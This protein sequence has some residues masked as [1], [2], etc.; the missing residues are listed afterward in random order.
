MPG[1]K[2]S[3]QVAFQLRNNFDRWPRD[4]PAEWYF[5]GACVGW[6][7]GTDLRYSP[8]N[9]ILARKEGCSDPLAT[10]TRWASP[11]AHLAW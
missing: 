7:L 9:D 5:E 11:K 4:T 3:R 8:E 6:P 10:Q 2:H 1:A